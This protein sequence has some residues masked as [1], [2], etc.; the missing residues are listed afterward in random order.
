L[1]EK[2]SRL[3]KKMS[4]RRDE[5]TLTAPLKWV[6]GKRRLVPTLKEF[7]KGHEYRRLV[8]PFCGGLSVALGLNT[9]FALLN[10]INPHLINFYRQ[11]E[12]DGLPV[13]LPMANGREVF[14]AHKTLFNLCVERGEIDTPLAAQL[15]Y[16]LNRTCFNGLCR[17]NQKGKFNVAFG[18]YKAIT[19]AKDFDAYLPAFSRWNFKCV[20]FEELEIFADDFIYADPPYDVEFTTYSPSGFTWAD[21]VRCAEWLASQPCPVVL[22]NQ[23]TARI[24]ALYESL[25]FELTE[26][27]AARTISCT[28]DRTPAREVLASRNIYTTI[29]V[30]G[31]SQATTGQTLTA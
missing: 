26:L 21:Q 6:G 7:W 31:L 3:E 11:V 9:T 8:E 25:G 19:Y 1:D 30:E 5:Q 4:K 10:D 28:G 12:Y 22:S 15:F 14:D 18:K 27:D 16:Y 29:M 20:D 2:L 17:F 24:I 13:T 23:A